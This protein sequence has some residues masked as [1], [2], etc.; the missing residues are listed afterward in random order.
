MKK[1]FR[2]NKNQNPFSLLGFK[3]GESRS[4]FSA[5]HTCARLGNVYLSMTLVQ[6]FG[7][8][9]W[10][11]WRK[12]TQNPKETWIVS[13]FSPKEFPLPICLTRDEESR[14]LPRA[15]AVQG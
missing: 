10:P 1:I 8:G 5:G 14:A 7:R 9:L 6:K 15:P 4:V 11:C 2:D 12:W 13:A 3:M